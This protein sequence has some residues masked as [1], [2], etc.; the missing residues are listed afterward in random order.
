MVQDVPP[1]VLAQG[2]H[3]T[4]YGLNLVGLQRNGFEKKELHA[5][6]RAYKEIYRSGKTMEEVKPVLAEMA[7]EWPSVGL[8]LDALNNTERGIIR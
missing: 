5:L 7:E 2:N 8:L 4:P 3:A 6:R 1:Y